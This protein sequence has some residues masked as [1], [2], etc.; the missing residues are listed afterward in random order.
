M[1]ASVRSTHLARVSGGGCEGCGAL[2]PKFVQVLCWRR[3]LCGVG[4]LLEDVSR[5]RSTGRSS[6][7]LVRGRDFAATL[8]DEP[9]NAFAWRSST[10]WRIMVV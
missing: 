3:G 9:A 4:W 6:S 5:E 10:R 8:C 7:S 1:S 2:G